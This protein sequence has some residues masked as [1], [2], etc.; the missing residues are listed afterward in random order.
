MAGV[1][2]LEVFPRGLQGMDYAESGSVG[3]RGSVQP[4]RPSFQFG[5]QFTTLVTVDT[6]GK[7][8]APGALGVRHLRLLAVPAHPER[9]VCPAWP[10]HCLLDGFFIVAIVTDASDRDDIRRSREMTL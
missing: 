5:I 6:K 2:L 9:S 1:T 3:F 7:V 10:E 4:G 8:V